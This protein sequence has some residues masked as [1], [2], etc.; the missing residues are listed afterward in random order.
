MMKKLSIGIVIL[1]VV[2]QLIPSGLPDNSTDVSNDLIATNDIPLEVEKIL[3]QSCYDCHSNQSVLP[4]YAYVAPVKFLVAKDIIEGREHLNFS[5]WNSLSKMD[6]IEALDDLY[7]EVEEAEMPMEIYTVMHSNSKL[8]ESQ[9]EILM[10]WA[11]DF[12]ETLF[13]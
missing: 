5:N 1:F 2:I 3:Q 6:K 9:R 11:E 8:T 10:T 12:T 7:E 13:E 4:W